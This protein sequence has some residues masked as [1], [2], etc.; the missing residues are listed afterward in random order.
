LPR[1][2]KKISYTCARICGKIPAIREAEGAMKL[3]SIAIIVIII[4][5]ILAWAVS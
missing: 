3:Y 2:V 4:G 1:I 5:G